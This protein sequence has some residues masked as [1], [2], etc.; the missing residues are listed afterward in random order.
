MG[1]FGYGVNIMGGVSE[2]YCG[3]DDV[4]T[5]LPPNILVEGNVDNLDPLNPAPYNISIEDI[6]FFIDKAC[7]RI[8]AALATMY[9]VP[10]KHINQ[11]GTVDFPSPIRVVAA[12]LT[13]QMIFEQRLQGADRERSESQKQREKWAEDELLLVQNGERK[14]LGIRAT[15]GNRFVRGTLPNVPRNPAQSGKSEGHK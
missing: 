7:I 1:G 14:L 11:G 4:T 10:L 3:V 2:R 9:D 5:F 12:I 8:D 13:S 15:R 6:E